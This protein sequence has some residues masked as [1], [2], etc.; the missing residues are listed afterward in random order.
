MLLALAD[1]RA[2]MRCENFATCAT[3]LCFGSFVRVQFEYCE[4]GQTA[5]AGNGFG[6]QMH[7][8]PA[9]AVIF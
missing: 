2:Q 8:N 6:E 3:V 4:E 5:A 1:G 7:E 9:K